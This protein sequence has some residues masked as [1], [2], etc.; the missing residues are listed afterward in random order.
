MVTVEALE[1]SLDIFGQ[2][3][4]ARDGLCLQDEEGFGGHDGRLVLIGVPSVKR[5]KKETLKVE[6]SSQLQMEP[7]VLQTLF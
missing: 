2:L 5:R 7:G 1:Q 6:G 3:V 4:A